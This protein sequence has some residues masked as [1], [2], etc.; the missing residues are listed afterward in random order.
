M[1]LVRELE[2]DIWGRTY[3]IVTKRFGIKRREYLD[4]KEQTE[5]TK[6]PEIRDRPEISPNSP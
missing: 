1:L 2:N 3:Q 4:T 5:I 6:K